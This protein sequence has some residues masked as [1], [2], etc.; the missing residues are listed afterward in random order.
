MFLRDLLRGDW[1]LNIQRHG[2]F[3]ILYGSINKVNIEI[4]IELVFLSKAIIQKWSVRRH[5]GVFDVRRGAS[6]CHDEC[7]RQHKSLLNYI[8][9][10]P[11]VT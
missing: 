5:N 1:F 10:S 2:L 9:P 4:S 11:L 3:Y 6:W 7:V 8:V